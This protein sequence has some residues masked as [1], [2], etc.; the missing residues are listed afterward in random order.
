MDKL[1]YIDGENVS[2]DI[3]IDTID[4]IKDKLDQNEKF[5]GRLY[6]SREFVKN[7]I[8]PCLIRGVVFVETSVLSVSKKNVADMK[9][10]IDCMCDVS[11]YCNS[12]KSCE[13]F[14]LTKDTDFFPLIFKLIELGIDVKT[15]LLS[16]TRDDLSQN[17]RNVLDSYL[18][19]EGFYSNKNL[20][21]LNNIYDEIKSFVGDKFSDEI[22]EAHIDVHTKKFFKWLDQ[23]FSLDDSSHKF[24]TTLKDFSLADL[25]NKLGIT[26]KEILD[27]IYLNYTQK[28]FGYI[29]KI[30]TM[31][32]IYFEKLKIA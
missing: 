18:K 20:N 17:S 24:Y 4:G 12:S 29:P 16:L 7:A 25:I 19:E 31:P 8:T 14:L 32:F 5:I 22:I 1:L 28:I 13:V 30:K 11:S 9:I 6:G 23:K 2:R 26:D 3:I 15:P 10:I 27:E 21:Y